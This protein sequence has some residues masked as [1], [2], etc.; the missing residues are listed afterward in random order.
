MHIFLRLILFI[1]QKIQWEIH[2]FHLHIS[3][4][5]F[6]Q[7]G[8]E[9]CKH[10]FIVAKRYNYLCMNIFCIHSDCYCVY[11]LQQIFIRN[12]QV[13]IVSSRL[14][15]NEESFDRKHY[16]AF[17]SK[18]MCMQHHITYAI[19][20]QGLKMIVCDKLLCNVIYANQQLLFAPF[21]Q[22]LITLICFT[23]T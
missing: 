10:L 13:T 16:N 23:I 3:L 20:V 4:L 19:T 22:L 1:L 9:N 15:V 8:Y 17:I 12:V 7:N 14:Y 6:C 11:S 5:C 21:L 18:Y 2:W